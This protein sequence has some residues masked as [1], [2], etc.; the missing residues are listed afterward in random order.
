MEELRSGVLLLQDTRR[1]VAVSHQRVDERVYLR[2]LP[3][4]RQVLRW[5]VLNLVLVLGGFVA[6]VDAF[7]A[8]A[9]AH[10]HGRGVD[11]L[12]RDACE[13]TPTRVGLQT[14]SRIFTLAATL[15]RFLRGFG[16][17][18]CLEVVAVLLELA[19]GVGDVL[20]EG[21]L[22]RVLVGPALDR[23]EE[24]LVLALAVVGRELLPRFHL[25]Q[26]KLFIYI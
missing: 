10:V 14:H 18:L 19:V 6:L 1:V 23:L 15:V 2:L 17:V 20:G 9:V 16:M 3:R 8:G 13:G 4:D 22:G 12:G 25:N 11:D 24:M 5:L 21:A 26:F 7:V